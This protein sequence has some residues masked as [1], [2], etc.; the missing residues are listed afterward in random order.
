MGWRPLSAPPL[1]PT[2]TSHGRLP[3]H[4][5]WPRRTPGSYG[6]V[7]SNFNRIL[8]IAPSSPV[9]SAGFRPMDRIVALNGVAA[10][11]G[12]G[13]LAEAIGDRLTVLVGVERPPKQ[14]F[15]DIV[16]ME[17]EE[18]QQIHSTA[19]EFVPPPPSDT[20]RPSSA[21]R[22]QITPSLVGSPSRSC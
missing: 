12:E 15:A 2:T 8:E 22:V 21:I 4:S 18:G 19:Y 10:P 7:L 5:R 9:A 16:A 17:S 6:L 14:L 3:A 20:S 13:K 1:Q 11:I